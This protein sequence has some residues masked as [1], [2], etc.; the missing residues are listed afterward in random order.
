MR[1]I[2]QRRR[3]KMK[4]VSRA[5]RGG[6]HS[7]KPRKQKLLMVVVIV[8]AVAVLLLRMAVFVHGRR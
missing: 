8:F 7:A 6:R 4:G 2:A 1:R 5:G 3:V